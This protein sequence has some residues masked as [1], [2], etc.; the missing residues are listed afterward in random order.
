MRQTF[1]DSYHLM[2][3]PVQQPRTYTAEAHSSMARAALQWHLPT[4]GV[5]CWLLPL[6][7]HQQTRTLL[8]RTLQL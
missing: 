4:A 5:A 3:V 1:F 7:L 8:L 2:Y 6:Q